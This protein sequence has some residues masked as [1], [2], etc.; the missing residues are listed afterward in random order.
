LLKLPAP[1]AGAMLH[2][3][4]LFAGSPA[5]LAVIAAVP[6]ACT[7]A[8]GA[9]METTTFGGGGGGALLPPQ[10][11]IAAHR[12]K[13]EY[14]SVSELDFTRPPQTWTWDP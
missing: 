8:T 3:T 13:I 10:P 9:L 1:D 2:V 14:E 7:W 11:A 12:I 5:A 4:P 6:P